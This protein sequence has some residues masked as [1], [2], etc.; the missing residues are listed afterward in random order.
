MLYRLRK[1][2]DILFFVILVCFICLGIF[3]ARMI[4]LVGH[5]SIFIPVVPSNCLIKSAVTYSETTDWAAEE[6]GVYYFRTS[7]D[8]LCRWD[9]ETVETLLPP[10]EFHG[11]YLH[12]ENGVLF[13]SDMEAFGLFAYEVATGL[14]ETIVDYHDLRSLR[15]GHPAFWWADEEGYYFLGIQQ[16]GTYRIWH[17]DADGQNI[18]GQNVPERWWGDV[19]GWED[20]PSALESVSAIT[21]DS[22]VCITESGDVGRYNYTTE[23]WETLLEADGE[24]YGDPIG[25]QDGKLIF[26]Q[27]D[28]LYWSV[29]PE[30]GEKKFF[31]RLDDPALRL[32]AVQG[33]TVYVV[34]TEAGS[35]IFGWYGD[36]AFSPIGRAGKTLCQVGEVIFV[37]G[38]SDEL[39]TDREVIDL[40]GDPV[41]GR[42]SEYAVL[43]N[44]TVYRLYAAP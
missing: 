6:D 12:A 8:A 14:S 15:R 37:T 29:D 32:E 33:E 39:F 11:E 5:N 25:F 20:Y 31:V 35:D 7:D 30:T 19:E 16:E 9:G 27:G 21:G 22:L 42:I 18:E 17:T 26:P 2:P 44:G 13:Y 23:E 38:P 41:D 34:R 36:A 4:A 40:T 24:P 1:R 43:S 10:G 28:S 3:M